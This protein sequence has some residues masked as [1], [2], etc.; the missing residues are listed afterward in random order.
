MAVA[1]N[2]LIAPVDLSGLQSLF[3][4][5]GDAAD[6]NVRPAAQA[7]AQVFYDAAGA[8]VAKIPRVSGKLAQALY[9]AF[10][11]DN[12]GP[13]LAEYHISWNARKA[14]HGGL[15]EYGHWQRYQVVMTSKGWVTAVR[16]EMI[17]KP[18]P[19]RRASQAE[20]DA[21]YMPRPGGPIYIPGRA[22][23]RGAMRAA[24]AAVLASAAVLWDA[25]E[26]VK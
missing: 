8:N 24:P 13:G 1:A 23:M 5:L 22:F 11:A 15:V 14:P 16:P 10:S 20:K 26:K 4:D 2:S 9:Q 18:K 17:G 21:Y 25:L 12:S 6:E 19:R 3:D 7:A